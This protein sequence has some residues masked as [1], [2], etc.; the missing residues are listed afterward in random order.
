MRQIRD[1]NPALACCVCGED[2]LRVI[3]SHHLFGRI[4]SDETIPLCKNCHAKNTFDQN[5]VSP[6]AR[7]SSASSNQKM[8]YALV[9]IGALLELIGRFLKNLGHEMI[10]DE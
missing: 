2:D 6:I 9:S 7:S 10:E 1:G 3:E 5:K 4:N 8:G